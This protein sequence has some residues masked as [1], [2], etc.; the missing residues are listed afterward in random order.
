MTVH[1][2][3]GKTISVW[4]KTAAMP[5][6]ISL[7]GD[8]AADVC[9]VGAGI[10]GLS[11]AYLLAKEGKSV[12][13]LEDGE[14]GSGE[15]GRTTAHVTCALDDR[16]KT[17]EKLHGEEGVR[18]AAHSHAAA[19]DCIESIVGREKIDCDFQRLD[20][21]LFV[22]PGEK[23]D[24]LEEELE[25]AR[26]C[27]LEVE[28]VPR[29]PL[30]SYDT[31]P[32]LRFARQAQFHPL[33]YLA[34]LVQ[35]I[36][37]LK[38]T[39]Y[40]G[41]H[42]EKVEDGEPARVVTST[43]RTVTAGAVVVAT[44]VPIND[45]LVIHVKQAP[46]R[47]YVVGMRVPR[48]AVPRALFWDTADPYHYVR[49]QT[50]AEGEEI[51]IVGGEDHRTGQKDDA[52]ERWGHLE[53]W[54]RERVPAVQETVYRWSGQVV[55]PAD[56]LAFIGRNPGE[57]HVYI[58][59]GDSGQGM[60]HGTIAGMLLTDLVMGRP[61]DWATVYD[62][63]R[64][65]LRALPEYAREMAESNAPLVKDWVTPGE[66]SSPEEV[67][68]GGGAVMRKGITK[69]AIYR[70]SVGNVLEVSA[71]CRH[72]GCIVHWNHSEKSWDCP[73]HGSRYAPDGH[74]VNGPAATGLPLVKP[75]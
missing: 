30:G 10:A 39:V 69:V 38:G 53:K 59:T 6:T 33:R 62:P 54:T 44:N 42:V 18:R 20:G 34:G 47:T 74:V 40:T 56:A 25:I 68:P 57:R 61:N 9:V 31:G 49:L 70:D 41:V 27:G 24:I 1:S 32:A 3:S 52:E 2:D 12:V 14:I 22:P 48:G 8:T 19:I 26:R 7:T 23:V 11:T 45:R 46:Y 17:L 28:S 43:G 29:A 60:T 21:Y 65:T 15:T 16:F 51:L 55:E 58:A 66:V 75:E 36:G 50:D 37:T 4:M 63:G 67:P 73:C 71:V 72:L 13:V 35:A 64:K 5:K